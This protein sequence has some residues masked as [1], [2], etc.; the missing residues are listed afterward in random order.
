M[1]WRETN[2]C[3]DYSQVNQVPCALFEERGKHH[4]HQPVLHTTRG[5][6]DYEHRKTTAH[7]RKILGGLNFLKM[8]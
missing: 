8:H 2:L 6:R 1:W 4:W 7:Y 5:V 3:F